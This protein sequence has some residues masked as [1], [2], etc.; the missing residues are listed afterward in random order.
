MDPADRTP[1]KITTVIWL[2][3]SEKQTVENV[4]LRKKDFQTL[5]YL[6]VCVCAHAFPRTTVQVWISCGYSLYHVGTE[7]QDHTRLGHKGL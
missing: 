2:L 5:F 7:D 3:M 6:C 1:A 4:N